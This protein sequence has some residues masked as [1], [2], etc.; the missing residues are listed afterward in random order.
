MIG[1]E[2]KDG[3]K[4]PIKKTCKEVLYKDSCAL[5]SFARMD[6]LNYILNVAKVVV[7]DNGA[8]K[9][10]NDRRKGKKKDVDPI[11]HWA[12]YYRKVLSIYSRIHWFLIPD[13][14]EGT[15]EENDALIKMLPIS[16]RNKAVPVWHSDESFDRLDRLCERWP[17]VAIGMCGPHRKIESHAAERRIQEIF[18]HLYC[19][20]KSD[21]MIHGLRVL[22]GRVLG[23]FP[24]HSGDSSFVATNVPKTREFMP[25]IQCKLA[26]TAICKG[27]IETVIPPTVEEWVRNQELNNC[28]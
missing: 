27:K 26:R 9:D 18:H 14:I 13:V 16:L 25:D 22:D 5:V 1:I 15:E 3:K 11:T 28:N 10:W 4:V 20:K 7:F 8:F 2:V 12:K 23:R 24:Y 17:M 6:Q 21:V 19:V